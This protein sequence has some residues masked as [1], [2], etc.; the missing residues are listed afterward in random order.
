MHT[1]TDSGSGLHHQCGGPRHDPVPD[2][3]LG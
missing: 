1:L 2:N 3:Y